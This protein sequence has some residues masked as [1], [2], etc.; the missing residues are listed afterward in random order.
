MP[1]RRTTSGNEDAGILFTMAL[2]RASL[3]EQRSAGERSARADHDTANGR[4]S[5]RVVRSRP[6]LRPAS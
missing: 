3:E 2:L 6:F 1:I 4:V 5:M